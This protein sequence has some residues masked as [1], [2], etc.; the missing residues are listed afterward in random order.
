MATANGACGAG[1][2]GPQDVS[3]AASPTTHIG[4]VM[5]LV[6]VLRSGCRYAVVEQ[7][8]AARSPLFAAACGTTVLRGAGPMLSAYVEAQEAHGPEPLFPSLRYC[9]NGGSPLPPGIFERTRD[10]LGCLGALS[11]WGLTEFA[12]ATFPPL[13]RPDLLDVG[14]GPVVEQVSLRVVGVDGHECGVGEE[15]ELRVTG[16]QLLLG[17]VDPALDQAAFDEHRYFRTGDLGFVDEHGHVHVTGRLKEIIIR[18]GEN[19]SA[20]RSSSS[21]SSIRPSP[22]AR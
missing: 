7:W 5:L 20:A 1:R 17:Y 22:T 18:N 9:L 2:I 4:G 13:D 6:V 21:C 12:V 15:G 19:I 11:S 14:V 8:D 10:T 3:P 16:P